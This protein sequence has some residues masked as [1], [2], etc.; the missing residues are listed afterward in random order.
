MGTVTGGPGAPPAGLAALA[1]QSGG[2]PALVLALDGPDGARAWAAGLARRGSDEPIRPDAPVRIASVTKTFVAAALLRLWE[3][4]RLDLDAPIRNLVSD[5]TR[6]ALDGDGYDTGAI[7]TRQLLAHTSGLVDHWGMR[8]YQLQARYLPGRRWTRIEQ[9]RFAM[10]H[11]EPVGAPGERF[12]YSDTG[13]LVAAEV[14]ERVSG[15]T[16]AEAVRSLLRFDAIGLNATWFETLE[17]RPP[18]APLQARQYIGWQDGNGIHASFDLFG[19]GGLVASAPDLARFFRAL[20]SG[21]VFDQLQTFL[22]M[23]EPTPQ[24]LAVRQDYGLGLSR[25]TIAG[26]ACIGH[27]GF[28]SHLAWVCPDTG[29]AGAIFVTDTERAWALG[30]VLDSLAP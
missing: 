5:E 10:R 17:P 11:G 29:Q 16:M 28:W 26:R 14:L 22:L 25:L 20:A 4:Q 1:A 23:A 30:P 21:G 19:A 27:G 7:T 12:H 18:G 24:S 6:A 15:Q 9:V 2:P 8:W 13:Y 3:Q